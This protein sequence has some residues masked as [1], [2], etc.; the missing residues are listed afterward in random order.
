MVKSADRTLD[1]FELFSRERQPLLLTDI[2]RGL[3]VPLSSCFNLVGALKER[4]YIYDVGHRREVYP[5]RKMLGIATI[6]AAH[7][8]WA[9]QLEAK[10]ADLRNTTRETTILGR[11][12]GNEVLYLAVYEGPQSIRYTAYAGDRKPLHS[13]SIGKALLSALDEEHRDS[14]VA[15]L[16]LDKRTKAT[17][18]NRKALS[19]ALAEA[20]M[21]GYAVTRGE[22]VAD[23]MAVAVPVRLGNELYAIAVAGPM[24][25][26]E[27]NMEN[28]AQ[29]L[30][31]LA[32]ELPR[33]A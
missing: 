14:I 6:T 12:Q 19:A 18:T 29:R 3:D 20:A 22:N 27:L 7:E 15:E 28:H 10:L 4:G 30:M 2:A 16:H 5:T 8:P 24:H 13:S 21:R 9:L 31:A 25:R 32:A 1:V 26:M 23:V 33:A 17:I 11:R